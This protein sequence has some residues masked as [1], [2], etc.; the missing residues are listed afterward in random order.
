VKPISIC[1]PTYN[2]ADKLAQCLEHLCT[3]VNQD[4]EVVIG[5]NCSTDHTDQVVAEYSQR[6]R[7]VVYLRH[8]TNLGFARNMDAILRRA[9]R[10]YSYI[11]ND[12]DIVFENALDLAVS[13]MADSE[14]MAVVGSYYSLRQLNPELTVSFDDAVVTTVGQKAYLA[15]LDN[16]SLCDGHPILRRSAFQRHCAYLDRTGTLIP[17]YFRLISLGKV[18]A[19]D[20]PFFQH[21]TTGDSLTARMAESWFLDM[22]NADLEL[23]VKEALQFLPADALSKARQR[24][25]HTLYFQAARMSITRN[26]PYLLWFFLQRLAGIGALGDDIA[27]LCE[28]HFAHDMLME[29]IHR[30]VKDTQQ[31]RL[32]VVNNSLCSALALHWGA[33]VFVCDSLSEALEL[34]AAEDAVWLDEWP[35]EA[36]DALPAGVS[37]LTDSL[38]QIRLTQL[39]CQ[40]SVVEGRLQMNF[41]QAEVQKILSEPNQGFQILCAPY[42]EA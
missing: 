15:L 13:L 38:S 41:T 25:L 32:L 17:L 22:A 4:F 6:L 19:I 27:V 23:A 29:R 14:V 30:Q 2:R 3:F 10:D 24:L 35:L 28:Y 16:L 20:K 21:R 39:P 33:D 42:S 31:Q 34:R 11:L 8:S 9:S 18:L 40:L 7:H 36:S 12:D 5:N 1:I 37:T 26:Q